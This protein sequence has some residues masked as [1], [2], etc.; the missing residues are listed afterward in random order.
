MNLKQGCIQ[1]GL[2]GGEQR[3]NAVINLQSQKIEN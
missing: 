3:K 2:K 1:K